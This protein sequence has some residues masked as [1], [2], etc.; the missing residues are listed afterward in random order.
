MIVA[1]AGSLTFS[2]PPESLLLYGKNYCR[3]KFI[4]QALAGVFDFTSYDLPK[5]QIAIK[6]LYPL[7]FLSKMK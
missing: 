4:V 1:K 3:K 2:G 6:N 7:F 5:S